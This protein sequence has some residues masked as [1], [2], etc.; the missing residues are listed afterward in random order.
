VATAW[1]GD[2]AGAAALI[3]EMD[4]IAAATGG[5]QAPFALLRLLALQGREPD[6]SAAVASAIELAGLGQG[7]AADWAHWAAAVLHNGL[8]HYG[9]AAAHAQCATSDARNWWSMWALPELVEAASRTGDTTLATGALERLAETT[10][11]CATDVALGILARCRALLGDGDAADR[12]FREAIERLGRTTLRP[13]LARAHLLYGEW[14]RR[15]N[16]R[17]RARG[18]LR[19]A[20]DLCVDIGMEAFAERARREL[21]IS[22]EKVSR[23]T[24]ETRDDLTAQERQIVQLARDGLTNPEIAARL[25]VSPR[26]VEWHLRNVFGKLGVR[27]RHEL[28]GP[29]G[30][31]R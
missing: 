30:T 29:R 6:A 4:S 14:L 3:A 27:S 26:T 23:R 17:A 18:Q 20:H 7:M 15:E 24:A 12:L 28:A 25:F 11:P 31:T 13:E 2:F 19:T 8:G 16:R 22:G 21:Q 5:A 10:E 1:T 9:E